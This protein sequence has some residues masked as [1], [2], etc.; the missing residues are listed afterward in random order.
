MAHGS[1]PPV[2]AI[3]AYARA[4]SQPPTGAARRL[5][6]NDDVQKHV[7]ELVKAGEKAGVTI[8]RVAVDDAGRPGSDGVRRITPVRWFSVTKTLPI[9][10]CGRA[11]DLPLN[12]NER[13]QSRILRAHHQGRREGWCNRRRRNA[14]RPTRT[15]TCIPYAVNERHF[16]TELIAS[17]PAAPLIRLSR[18]AAA[19][20][21][22]SAG[23]RPA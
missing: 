3:S 10:L 12:G 23:A 14:P 22:P 4:T 17:G 8:E 20:R 13:V 11:G 18:A 1:S 9:E 5:T 16:R 15:P 7:Y 6:T 21:P 19:V 2:S